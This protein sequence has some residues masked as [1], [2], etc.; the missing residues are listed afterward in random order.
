VFHAHKTRMTGYLRWRNCDDTLSHFD[1]I[2]ECDGQTELLSISRV[3]SAVLT[4]D[5]NLQAAWAQRRTQP[6]RLQQFPD[7]SAR[8]WG[9]VGRVCCPLLTNHIP[10]L[11][12]QASLSSSAPNLRWKILGTLQFISCPPLGGRLRV[13]SPASVR[14][15]V[16]CLCRQTI[17]PMCWRQAGA[18]TATGSQ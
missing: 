5:K 15:S 13:A 8:G 10:T 4:F 16:P 2:P 17:V 9:L 11:T 3:R 6:E 18:A 14:Q 1:T 12:F 7:H